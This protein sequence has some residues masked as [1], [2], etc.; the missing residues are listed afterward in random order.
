M[1]SS[2]PTALPGD[3]EWWF[4]QITY[5]ATKFAQVSCLPNKACYMCQSPGRA[6]KSI[7][8]Q[9]RKAGLQHTNYKGYQSTSVILS[10]SNSILPQESTVNSEELWEI[11]C[12]MRKTRTLSTYRTL[13]VLLIRSSSLSTLDHI[14]FLLMTWNLCEAG[15]STGAVIKSKYCRKINV[16]QEKRG[17]TANP[18]W[19]FETFNSAPQTHN[20]VD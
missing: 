2:Y 20:H 18:I 11:F 12:F 19:K 8:N 5:S 14:P 16:E 10:L 1:Q 9:G 17:A 6:F 13:H 4:H 15:F 7:C 3:T